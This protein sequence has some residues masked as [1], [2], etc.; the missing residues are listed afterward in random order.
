MIKDITQNRSQDP[1]PV[2]LDSLSS[3]PLLFP[4]PCGDRQGGSPCLLRNRSSPPHKPVSQ[5]GAQFPV[6]KNK[7]FAK[8][9]VP[10]RLEKDPFILRGVRW[11][12]RGRWVRTGGKA[13]GPLE[14]T[15]G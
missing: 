7:N 6:L 10:A 2:G 3:G 13:L 9:H 15:G 4:D 14:G 5:S 8:S 12:D 1:F 11:N